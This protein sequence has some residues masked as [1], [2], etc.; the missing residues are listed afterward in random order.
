VRA[1]VHKNADVK[2]AYDIFLK[3]KEKAP[4]QK[5]TKLLKA[6]SQSGSFD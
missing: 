5:E 3:E 2:E 1:I 6:V 4:Q